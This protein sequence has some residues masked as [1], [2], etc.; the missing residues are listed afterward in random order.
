M[1]YFFSVVSLLFAFATASAQGFHWEQTHG[2]ATDAC[3]M[4]AVNGNGDIVAG[5]TSA[6]V[7]STDHGQ[8]WLPFP[9]SKNIV[10]EFPVFAA[11]P[12]G[13]IVV[14]NKRLNFDGYGKQTTLSIASPT[15]LYSDRAG[16][17]YALTS[18]SA[19][20][21]SRSFDEGNS[22][23]S[24]NGPSGETMNCIGVDAE[25]YYVGT[26]TGVYISSDSG[27]TWKRVLNTL[28]NDP[29]VEIETGP[30]GS[31]WALMNTQFGDNSALYR[32]NDFGQTWKLISP[33]QF[34]FEDHT[35][36]V[37][38]DKQ[39]ILSGNGAVLSIDDTIVTQRPFAFSNGD[40]EPEFNI[41]CVDSSGN[42]LESGG[43]DDT[44]ENYSIFTST[45]FLSSNDSASIWSPIPAPLSSVSSLYSVNNTLLALLAVGTYIMGDSEN[46]MPKSPSDVPNIVVNP[47]DNSLLGSNSNGGV[48]R[49]TD[50]GTTW[51]NIF[52][53]A[54]S[55]LMYAAATSASTIYAG[56]QGVYVTTNS[57]TTW[58]ETNDAALGAITGLLS[59][60]SGT[61]YASSTKGLFVSTNSGNSWSNISPS[62]AFSI[63]SLCS[64]TAGVLAL[65][66]S[67]TVYRSNDQG[68][69]WQ[70]VSMPNGT[71]LVLNTNGDVF[72]SSTSGV[73]Y[74][75]NHGTLTYNVSDSLQ[76]RNVMALAISSDGSLYAA[77]PGLGVWK[78][79]GDLSTLSVAEATSA[80][81]VTAYPNP[82][83]SNVNI[84]LPTDGN[85]S[86]IA[87]DALGRT[88]TMSYK[89]SG[90]TLQ[91]DLS[92][93]VPGAYEIVLR[94]GEKQFVARIQV[95]R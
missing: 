71:G 14:G 62:G 41:S 90:E 86:V 1:R 69:T 15:F 68:A 77:V 61:L 30:N 47:Y 51:T 42:W 24:F 64:N 36:A 40:G 81:S 83:S 50:S 43:E 53:S 70:S 95:I 17:L 92:T 9:N 79:V 84:T 23:K 31:V 4:L 48:D 7:R 80:N 45:V 26:N 25:H 3:W 38:N 91:C 76:G 87:L 58:N 56:A 11:L 35:L 33:T 5:S 44:R 66:S 46:W 39:A 67:G 74:W 82:A 12:D 93:L 78:G 28:A 49:S 16:N 94:S 2:P 54:P 27:A 18:Y 34:Q 65:T 13:H 59:D 60:N 20:S 21:V 63:N 85:W 72:A 10:P 22:W 52:P 8:H 89:L 73:F 19:T 88:C 55:G 32:S 29:Y 57:G 6:I 37:K 75:P